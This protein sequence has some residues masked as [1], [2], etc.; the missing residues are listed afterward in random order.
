MMAAMLV[1]AGPANAGVIIVGSN[2]SGFN[3][4]G[5]FD[6]DGGDV[7]FSSGSVGNKSGG[8]NFSS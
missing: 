2:S 8:V 4:G 1:S 6:F 7:N 3:S 5:D